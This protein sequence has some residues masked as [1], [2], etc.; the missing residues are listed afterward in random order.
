MRQEASVVF[1]QSKHII[2]LLIGVISIKQTTLALFKI[3]MTGRAFFGHVIHPQS[4]ESDNQSCSISYCN[5]KVFSYLH[6]SFFSTIDICIVRLV[7]S[8]FVM[9]V[10]CLLVLHGTF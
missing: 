8:Y 1:E 5:S 2:G 10:F 6:P 3:F 9:L 4:E 7:V